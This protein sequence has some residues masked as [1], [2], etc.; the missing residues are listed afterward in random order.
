MTFE[1]GLRFFSASSSKINVIV[2]SV[3]EV[4]VSDGPFFVNAVSEKSHASCSRLFSDIPVSILDFESER[5]EITFRISGCFLGVDGV[6][7]AVV[8]QDWFER[9]K[10][11][12][13][14]VVFVIF[15]S[16][17]ASFVGI[18]FSISLKLSKNTS[19]FLSSD[20]YKISCQSSFFF[21]LQSA[22]I[23]KVLQ[24]TDFDWVAARLLQVITN[25][26]LF[27]EKAILVK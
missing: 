14:S 19:S 2:F 25:D 4:Q 20:L 11:S 22:P 3:K 12:N 16:S 27:G 5:M 26:L 23:V 7:V 21:T 9:T 17:V 6:V 18:C 8:G 15:T 24:T 10:R 13:P 1:F